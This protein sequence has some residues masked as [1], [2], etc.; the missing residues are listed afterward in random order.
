MDP[1]KLRFY[2]ERYEKENENIKFVEE[3]IPMPSSKSVATKFYAKHDIIPTEEI[4][5][6]YIKIIARSATLTPKDIYN[7]RPPTVNMDYGWFTDP[8]VPRT[9]DPRLYFPR[10]GCDFIKNELKLRHL[11][12]GVPVEKFTGAPFKVR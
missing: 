3:F 9:T 11:N 10:A 12:K 2:L 1:I 5:L 6:E 8:L 4:P 7:F